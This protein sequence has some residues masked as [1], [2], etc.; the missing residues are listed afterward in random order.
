[1]ISSSP[2]AHCQVCGTLC[3]LEKLQTFSYFYCPKCKDETSVDLGLTLNPK[4]A[5]YPYAIKADNDILL[6]KPG[7]YRIVYTDGSCEFFE[8]KGSPDIPPTRLDGSKIRAATRLT[9][10]DMPSRKPLQSLSTTSEG[11]EA[12]RQGLRAL[13]DAQDSAAGNKKNDIGIWQN[14]YRDYLCIRDD[15]A[16]CWRRKN[17]GVWKDPADDVIRLPNGCYVSSSFGETLR[18]V[19]EGFFGVEHGEVPPNDTL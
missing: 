6:D 12:Q 1:M 17:T 3:R 2:T 7:I 4:G 9:E 18:L 19:A 14:A 11:E 13:S 5:K 16:A 15:F 8:R 10:S